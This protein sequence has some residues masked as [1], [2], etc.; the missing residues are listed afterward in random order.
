MIRRLFIIFLILTFGSGVCL[1]ARKKKGI[2]KVRSKYTF[3]QTIDRLEDEIKRNKLTLFKVIDHR[4][5]ALD[6]GMRLNP[7]TLFIVGNPRAGTPLM[8]C[9]QSF[10]LDLPQKILV[11]EDDNG[12]VWVAC[13]NQN[14][15][16][17]RHRMKKCEVNLEQVQTILKNMVK[18]AS[19]G[20]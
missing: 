12:V 7:T 17:K 4:E 6:A 16:K 18:E 15:L 2:E 13:N 8:Q 19:L 3:T 14:F 20:E 5:N 1:A 11:Y 10:A 9:E